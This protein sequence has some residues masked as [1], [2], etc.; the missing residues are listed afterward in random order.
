MIVDERLAVH[1]VLARVRIVEDINLVLEEA[2][3]SK[4]GIEETLRDQ[5]GDGRQ[6]LEMAEAACYLASVARLRPE[7]HKH[8]VRALTDAVQAFRDL[9]EMVANWMRQHNASLAGEQ[10]L[11]PLTANMERFHAE[12]ALGLQERQRDISGNHAVF[13][14]VGTVEWGE[15]NRRRAELIRKK[16]R[17]ELSESEREEYKSLQRLSLAAVEASFPRQADANQRG[18]NSEASEG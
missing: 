4:A 15:M 2:E 14:Q 17:D 5:I 13:P 16:I 10:E 9:Q 18:E 6:L 12:L 1:R 8:M 7:T 3:P 11:G